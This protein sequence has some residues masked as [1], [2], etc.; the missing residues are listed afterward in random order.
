[1]AIDFNTEIELNQR[2]QNVIYINAIDLNETT[3]MI[4][5]LNFRSFFYVRAP[6]FEDSSK[7][8]HYLDEMKNALNERM[9]QKNIIEKLEL[10]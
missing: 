9:Q 10:V 3:F 5:V 8:Q 7:V 6:V 2:C 1:M 4:K